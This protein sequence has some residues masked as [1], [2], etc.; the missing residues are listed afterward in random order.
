MARDSRSLS[1]EIT[2]STELNFSNRMTDS[3]ALSPSR[4]SRLSR[5]YTTRCLSRV[6]WG[7]MHDTPRSRM[8]S[9]SSGFGGMPVIH[10]RGFVIFGGPTLL[11]HPYPL[12]SSGSAY[13]C[14]APQIPARTA[15]QSRGHGPFRTFSSG[16]RS[17]P[18]PHSRLPLFQLVHRCR[19]KSP[20]E[21]ATAGAEESFPARER[22]VVSDSS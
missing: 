18:Q 1:I 4:H 8:R 14:R 11:S 21:Q 19:H 15:H 10:P 16:R 17:K 6:P 9:L 13:R 5:T 2:T 20:G 7:A 3:T 22:P 12:G